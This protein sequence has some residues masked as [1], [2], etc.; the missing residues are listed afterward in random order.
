MGDTCRGS[1]P[2]LAS[3][4]VPQMA[5]LRPLGKYNERLSF[6]PESGLSNSTGAFGVKTMNITC[7]YCGQKYEIDSSILGQN[8]ECESCRMNFIANIPKLQI[9]REQPERTILQIHPSGW[10]FFWDYF[11]GILLLIV[12]LG[13]VFIARGIINQICTKYTVT[14]HRIIV[15]TGWLNKHRTEVWIKDIRGASLDFSIWER[16]IGTGSI[17]IGT[18]ATAG[19]EIKMVGVENP[20][21]IVQTINGL[22]GKV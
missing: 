17:A 3:R 22:R 14:T 2:A 5:I 12:I 7:P 11:F 1:A 10:Y 21:A 16:I 18:A 8:V 9:K 15:E 6:C 19:V 4:C 13:I 20:Q